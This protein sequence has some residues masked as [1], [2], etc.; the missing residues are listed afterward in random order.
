MAANEERQSP[1]MHKRGGQKTWKTSA[2]RRYNRDLRRQKQRRQRR[3][4]VNRQIWQRLQALVPRAEETATSL[5]QLSKT[6]E[7]RTSDHRTGEEIL[8]KA[9][10]GRH[11]IALGDDYDHEET[12]AGR[13][14]Q[15]GILLRVAVSVAGRRCVAL[16]DSGAS[17]SYI[18]PE[19]VAMSEILCSPALVH[20]ELADGSKI[21]ATQQTLATPCTVGTAVCQLTFTVTKLLR[22]VDVV[23]GMDWLKTWNPVIDWRN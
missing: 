23:L 16:I 17:Q 1:T 11:W 9:M 5:M 13:R 21:E 6:I 7:E 18:S 2:R 14:V 19:T 8:Q 10:A 22:N 4:A 3:Q 20:L 15:D 12:N